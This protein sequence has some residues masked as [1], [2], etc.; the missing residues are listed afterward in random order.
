MTG[1]EI[2]RLAIDLYGHR[3]QLIKA[4][5]E[6][7]ELIQAIA[8]LWTAKPRDDAEAAVLDEAVLEE[9]ADM[10]IMLDQI[11]LIFYLGAERIAS[12]KAYKLTRLEKRL[13]E[14]EAGSCNTTD[15]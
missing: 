7:S 14:M 3:N 1:T 6:A 11:K 5:E 4:T 13:R 2:E 10:E 9:A 12:Y 15:S 8:K